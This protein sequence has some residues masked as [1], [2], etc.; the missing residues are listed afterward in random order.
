MTRSSRGCSHHVFFCFGDGCFRDAGRKQRPPLRVRIL[1]PSQ[2]QTPPI[3]SPVFAFFSPIRLCLIHPL[4]RSPVPM[5]HIQSSTWCLSLVLLTFYTSDGFVLPQQNRNW[6][7]VSSR[8]EEIT[9]NM[10][11]RQ[12]CPGFHLRKRDRLRRK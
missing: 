9:H 10:L 1:F 11:S 2:K 8:G 4:K 6:F 5:L 3:S 12:D 7:D